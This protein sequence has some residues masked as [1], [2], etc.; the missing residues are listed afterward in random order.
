[1]GGDWN[2]TYSLSDTKTNP[3]IVNMSAPPSII[4]SRWLADLCE[5][6]NLLDLYRAFHP[7]RRDFTFF[8][9]GNKKNRSRL[10]FFLISQTVLAKCKTCDISPWLSVST[11]DHKSVSLDF[12]NTK[13]KPKLYINRTITSNP[14]TDDVVLAAFADTYLAHARDEQ[15]EHQ[16]HVYHR[17]QLDELQEQKIVVGTFLRLLIDSN[18]LAE[19]AIKDPNDNLN[20][21]LIAAKNREIEIQR[22][23]FWPL[24]RFTN[25]RLRCDDDY[26]FE[27]LS[28]NIKGSVISFQTCVRRMDNLRKSILIKKL[29]SLRDNFDVNQEEICACEKDLNDLVNT[30][31][32]AK[33]KQM[34]I[35]T[36]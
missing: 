3:D 30:E 27:A 23:L 19:K 31:V 33:V 28:S 11:F 12:R 16:R 18:E 6:H 36:V 15:D 34:K 1:V 20:I 7:T 24:E 35:L 22:E 13:I 29:E 2:L 21:L 10:D 4:R 14:R 26:F 17:D 32:V 9:K 8:P 25:L 5:T